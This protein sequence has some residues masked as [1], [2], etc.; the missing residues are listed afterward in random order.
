MVSLDATKDRTLMK[1]FHLSLGY[2]RHFNAS[3]V[4]HLLLCLNS[5]KVGFG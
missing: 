1:P 4:F 5:E 2:I 3:A